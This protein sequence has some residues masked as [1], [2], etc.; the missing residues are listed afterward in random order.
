VKKKNKKCNKKGRQAAQ[1][2]DNFVYR[3][4]AKKTPAPIRAPAPTLTLEAAPVEEAAA[5]PV[6]ELADP[7]AADVRE[8]AEEAPREEEPLWEALEPE[9]DAA[10]AP[11]EPEA[12]EPEPVAAITA[13]LRIWV[14]EAP[15][16]TTMEVALPAVTLP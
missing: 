14:V 1:T 2:V 7:E 9:D 13:A 11:E 10:A 4:A 15:T 6:A 12:E 8:E 3:K 5:E 16:V